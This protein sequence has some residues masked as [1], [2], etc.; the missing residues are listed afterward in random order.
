MI[1]YDMGAQDTTAT[2]VGYQ[3][4]KTKERGF[5]ETHP[6]VGSQTFKVVSSFFLP[7]FQGSVLN[8][9]RQASVEKNY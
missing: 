3:I 2:V 9:Y 8:N 1:F 7:E 4:V 5:A 6:Q